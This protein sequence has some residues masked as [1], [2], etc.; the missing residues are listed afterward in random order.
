MLKDAEKYAEKDKKLKELIGKSTF[1]SNIVNEI[2]RN[3]KQDWH[4]NPWYWD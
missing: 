4:S 3:E 1:Y 2:F